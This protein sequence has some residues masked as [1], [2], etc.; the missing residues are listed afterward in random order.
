MIGQFVDTS[1]AGF[2]S[3]AVINVK[4]ILTLR[5]CITMVGY[6]QVVRKQK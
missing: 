4:L 1:M 5:L 6:A 2:S 3:Q